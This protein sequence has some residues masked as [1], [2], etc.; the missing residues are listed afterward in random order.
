MLLYLFKAEPIGPDEM[1]HPRFLV[2]WPVVVPFR[3]ILQEWRAI[4]V[5]L[6]K[7]IIILLQIISF[8]T[9]LYL[10]IYLDINLI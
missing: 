10:F 3:Y 1:G 5:S 9:T 8:I 4:R 7:F 2:L 6:T